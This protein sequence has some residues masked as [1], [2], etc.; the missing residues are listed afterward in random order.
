MT[1]AQHLKQSRFPTTPCL[2]VNRQEIGFKITH[3]SNLM[4]INLFFKNKYRLHPFQ[5]G[6]F[7]CGLGWRTITPIRSNLIIPQILEWKVSQDNAIKRQKDCA[8]NPL[9][10]SILPIEPSVFSFYNPV[11]KK[12]PIFTCKLVSLFFSQ[13]HATHSS[14]FDPNNSETESNCV[15]FI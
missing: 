6:Q 1:P 14:H 12:V 3:Y 15:N 5:N 11:S 7:C 8:L 4:C 13:Q 10:H 2:V 9:L